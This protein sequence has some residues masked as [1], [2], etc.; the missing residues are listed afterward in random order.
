M[1]RSVIR[2]GCPARRS[3]A[4]A[5][6][7]MHADHEQDQVGSWVGQ[8]DC[9]RNRIRH[10]CNA[11][12]HDHDP[13]RCEGA[14]R[15]DRGVD[16]GRAL[17]ARRTPADEPEGSAREEDIAD[18]VAE[19]RHRRVGQFGIG[20]GQVRV[21]D[22]TDGPQGEGERDCQPRTSPPWPDSQ[23]RDEDRHGNREQEHRVGDCPCVPV[24]RQQLIERRQ[25]RG[26]D[27]ED[28]PGAGSPPAGA[29]VR[30]S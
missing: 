1:T 24:G 26:R 3:S 14:R 9:D 25:D 16:Q 2:P 20:Q 21:G 29:G 23:D 18:E 15:H 4:A 30:G 8:R 27:E 17:A 19:V 28:D 7:R 12:D 11:R 5:E 10:A 13:E 6:Q 22:V